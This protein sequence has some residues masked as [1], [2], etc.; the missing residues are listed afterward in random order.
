MVPLHTSLLKSLQLEN[1]FLLRYFLFFVPFWGVHLHTFSSPPKIRVSSTNTTGI[2]LPTLYLQVRISCATWLHYSCSAGC[3]HYSVCLN[4]CQSLL[5]VHIWCIEYHC[6][7]SKS[8]IF[9][10]PLSWLIMSR[11]L[12]LGQ[13]CWSFIT[14]QPMCFVL[15]P[16]STSL[17]FGSSFTRNVDNDPAVAFNRQKRA[18]SAHARGS[19]ASWTKQDRAL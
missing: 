10:R 8:N 16:E 7:E 3:Q 4:A 15:F 19:D 12:S 9:G 6:Y 18:A 17:F 2:M 1:S 14:P 11:Q 5:R 13:L